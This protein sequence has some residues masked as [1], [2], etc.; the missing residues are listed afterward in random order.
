MGLNR[1]LKRIQV[2]FF[3]AQFQAV[4]IFPSEHPPCICAIYLGSFLFIDNAP[5]VAR[6]LPCKDFRF[7]LGIDDHIHNLHKGIVSFFL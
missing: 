4:G 1:L 2:L 6:S 5:S 7:D 3:K